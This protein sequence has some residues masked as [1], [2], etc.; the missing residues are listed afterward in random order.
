LIVRADGETSLVRVQEDQKLAPCSFERIYF[1]RGSD[2]DIYKERKMLGRLLVEPILKSVDYDLDNSV[3]SFIPNTA[4]AAYFGMVEG[5]EDYLMD[6]KKQQIREPGA[7]FDKILSKRVRHEKVAVKDVKLRTFIAD[8]S[9]SGRDDLAAHVYDITYGSIV[10]Y[11]DNLVVI[12]DSIVRGTTLK[13]SIIKILDRLHPKKIVVVSSS[14]QIRYP[15][16]YGIDMRSMEEFI[17]FSA[18]IDLLKERGDEARIHR[19][20]E[21]SVA[22]LGLPRQEVVNYVKEIYEPFTDEEISARIA[23]LLTPAGTRAQVEIV[24][25]DIP[26]LHKA[27]PEHKGDWYFSGDYPT[28]GGNA[29]VNRAYVEYYKSKWK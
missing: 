23:K 7:D 12:D 25:Q 1:S 28:P 13:Q 14:P 6:L 26:G 21:L 24:Y 18:A 5:L 15:D 11:K 27:C 2:G 10:P 22:Q 9:E 19:V 8:N 16:C 29:V 4:E 20:Y 17:A 3:F